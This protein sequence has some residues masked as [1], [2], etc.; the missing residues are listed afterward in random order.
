MKQL[1]HTNTDIPKKLQEPFVTHIL[2]QFNS[3]Y[4]P[5]LMHLLISQFPLNFCLHFCSVSLRRLAGWLTRSSS[6]SLSLLIVAVAVY[7]VAVRHIAVLDIV[8]N[9]GD[10]GFSG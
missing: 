8:L 4:F 10:T 1:L 5:L 2:D 9:A 3:R 7:T 6:C